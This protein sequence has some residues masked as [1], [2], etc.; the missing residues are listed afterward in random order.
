MSRPWVEPTAPSRHGLKVW[1]LLY[2]QVEASA[3]E[4]AAAGVHA[5]ELAAPLVVRG[6]LRMLDVVLMP[7]YVPGLLR[8]NPNP[9]RSRNRNPSPNPTPNPNPN[10]NP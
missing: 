7:C 2:E 8:Q 10:T 9:N 6:S 5:A 1:D 3:A 4:A